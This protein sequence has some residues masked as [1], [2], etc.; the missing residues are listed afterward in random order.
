MSVLNLVYGGTIPQFIDDAEL[1]KGQNGQPPLAAL[2]GKEIGL[3]NQV[4]HAGRPFYSWVQGD[5]G[6]GLTATGHYPLVEILSCFRQVYMGANKGAT[7]ESGEIMGVTLADT[8]IAGYRTGQGFDISI[9]TTTVHAYWNYSTAVTTTYPDQ[10]TRVPFISTFGY[11]TVP[12]EVLIGGATANWPQPVA[13]S[14]W[15]D[16]VNAVDSSKASTV[17]G[18]DVHA[19]GEI[20]AVRGTGV[21]QLTSLVNV[22]RDTWFHQRPQGGWSSALPGIVDSRTSTIRGVHF[23]TSSQQFR[24]I[25]DQT[26]G[27]TGTTITASTPAITLP[28]FHAGGGISTQVRVYVFVYAAMSGA[29]NSGSLAVANK[30]GSGTMTAPTALVHGQAIS[31][32]TFQWYPTLASW[33]ATTCPYFLA[34]TNSAYDRVALCGKTTG[35]TDHLIVGAFTLIVM[36][37]SG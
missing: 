26:Y 34:Y 24:Y 21:E 18:F 10:S 23:T 17:G 29:T 37:A 35:A 15:Q 1:A 30:D 32:T 5:L 9:G 11:S 27:A 7:S 31:G 8:P 13:G 22:F 19:K 20:I 33:D 14:I 25:F 12:S 4:A 2:V 3:A 36:P 28:L 6:T 16:P